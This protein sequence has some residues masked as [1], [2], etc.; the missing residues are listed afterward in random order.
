MM[1]LEAYLLI[2]PF[3]LLA[4]AGLATWYLVGRKNAPLGSNANRTGPPMRTVY[5]SSIDAGIKTSYGTVRGPGAALSGQQPTYEV[6]TLR[7]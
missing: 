2:A 1:G 6:P 5:Q 4:V 7:H 3:A